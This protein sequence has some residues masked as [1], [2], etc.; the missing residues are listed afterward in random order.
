MIYEYECCDDVFEVIK[1]V[2]DIDLPEDCPHC[3]KPAR[4]IIS[5]SNFYG[6]DDW[7][8]AT[9]CPGLGQV[10]KSNKH[11]AKIARQRGLEE[12]GNEDM[13][14]ISRQA[15][16]ERQAQSQNRVEQAAKEAYNHGFSE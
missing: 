6:A 1:P 13:G 5:K 10:I 15:D 11:R 3:K 7:D 4:R 2:S 9:F 8:N 14:K 16:A 12:I